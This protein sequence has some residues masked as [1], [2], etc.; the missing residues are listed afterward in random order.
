MM[1]VQYTKR[2]MRPL[3]MTALIGAAAFFTP[4]MNVWA[5]KGDVA[6]VVAKQKAPLSVTLG[7]AELV[8][9]PGNVADVLVANSSIVDVQAVQSDRLYIVGLAIGDTNIIVLDEA[10]EV[11]DRIDVHVSYDLK[12]INALVS[13]MFPGETAK[14]SSLHGQMY[15]S[16][17][18][19]TPDKASKISDLVAH[20]VGEVQGVDHERADQI[21]SNLM[22]VKGEQQ[23]ML[24][25]KV[26]EA[27]RNFIRDLG[28]NTVANNL[29]LSDGA[30]PIFG[31]APPTSV[32]GG[33]GSVTIGAGG[34]IALP[35]DPAATVRILT[36][37]GILG[38]GTLGIFVDALE[39]ENLVTVL[40]EPNLTAIS[41]QQAGFLAGG[42][43]PVPVGRDQIGNLVIEYREFGVSL[44]FRPVVM[45][46]DRIN[47][48][49]NTE[50]SSLDFVNAVGAGDL[51]VPG[52]DVRRADTTIEIPSGGSLMI[53][54]LLQSDAVEGLAGLPGIRKAPILGDLVSSKSFNRNETELVIMISAY[55]VE[56]FADKK[57][58]E[59]VPKQDDNHLAKMFAANIR[60][61]YDKL[62]DTLFAYDEKF[63]Y[64][65]K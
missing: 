13:D 51:V 21:V 25:V 48:Q 55:L 15:L 32:R 39:Q 47:L 11:L 27:S 33:D 36:D 23:V 34:G 31:G 3:V 20:Y 24:Q 63:G 17:K 62:D 57:R 22:E 53:A 64:V 19:S 4:V 10:G 41:G 40:A 49:L 38:L 8:K 37:S 35:N 60:R 50:V 59:K 52:L 30:T 54:G 5:A 61:N 9:V 29:D 12:A 56:P 45:S 7:K 46:G 44:N 28:V 14:V 43:F 1:M 18:V 42:E 6:S 2:A 26:L 16:G 58:V 65:L